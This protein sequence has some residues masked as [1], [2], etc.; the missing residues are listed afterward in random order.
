LYWGYWQ[1]EVEERKVQAAGE[2]LEILHL[3]LFEMPE[4]GLYY[5]HDVRQND[6]ILTS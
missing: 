4:A 2:T 5:Y 6:R 3:G 1:S